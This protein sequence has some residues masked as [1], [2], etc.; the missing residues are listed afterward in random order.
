MPIE[1][2]DYPTIEPETAL[3]R[4]LVDFFEVL[5][6]VYAEGKKGVFQ[7]IVFGGCGSGLSWLC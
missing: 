4:A 5:E 3:G 1:P 7:A 6:A 2:L